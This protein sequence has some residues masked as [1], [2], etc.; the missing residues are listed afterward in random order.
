[1]KSIPK[2]E[3]EPGG[4]QEFRNKK[5]QATWEQFKDESQTAYQEV[6]SLLST[7]QSGLCAYCEID[8]VPAIDQRVEHFHPK[9]DVDDGVNWH[10]IWEN[11][12]MCCHGG[13]AIPSEDN[14]KAGRSRQPVTTNLSCDAYKGGHILDGQ[15]LNPCRLPPFPKVFKFR[16]GDGEIQVD[17][18]G[19]EQAG[20]ESELAENTIV[21]LNLNCPRLKDARAAIIREI[22]KVKAKSR[23]AKNSEDARRQ[24]YDY[25]ISYHLSKDDCLKL[26]RFFSV[27]RWALGKRGEY[28][29]KSNKY[30]G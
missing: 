23:T 2:S 8:A 29:L 30:K 4:L 16:I 25:L 27:R 19:C 10:L 11:L 13:Q 12:L 24:T 14:Q 26:K 22:E 1:M 5:P 21:N 20:V 9:H 15:I 3:Q 18:E 28:Y 17:E 7:D 6:L